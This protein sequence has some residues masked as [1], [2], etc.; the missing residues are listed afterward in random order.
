MSYFTKTP[1]EHAADALQGRVIE[2]NTYEFLNNA[3]AK[4][5]QEFINYFPPHQNS[6]WFH[7][8]KVILDV[9]LAKDAAAIAEKMAGLSRQ[10]VEQSEKFTTL[11]AEHIKHSE[12]LTRQ[13]DILITESI[14]L[15][16]LTKWII[17]LTWGVLG[18]TLVLAFLT[19][20]LLYIDW[21]KERDQRAT[22]QRDSV[23]LQ[24]D[25]QKL[26]VCKILTNLDSPNITLD[27]QPMRGS[28]TIKA[29]CPTN[30]AI[31][32]R[33][34]PDYYVS[35][36]VVVLPKAHFDMWHNLLATTTNLQMRI[37]INYTKE[38]SMAK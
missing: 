20:G 17:G 30:S 16:R 5:L 25:I 21:H 19:A 27:D 15:G 28:L 14:G 38:L 9:R 6:H 18:L 31:T 34:S 22:T 36:N 24:S 11:T 29:E 23:W 3:T 35:N 33:F 12:K 7:K 4:E 26:A 2:K 10:L 1:T 8:A 37:F 32:F 13:T